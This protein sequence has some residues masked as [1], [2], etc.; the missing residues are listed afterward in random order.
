MNPAYFFLSLV[1]LLCTSSHALFPTQWHHSNNCN[2][3]LLCHDIFSLCW[4]YPFSIQ[5]WSSFF[6]VDKYLSWPIFPSSEHPVPLLPFTANMPQNNYLVNQSSIYPLPF[7][8]AHSSQVCGAHKSTELLLSRPL[9]AFRLINPMANSQS[10]FYV[11]HH[12]SLPY[13]WNTFF[14]WLL[15]LVTPDFPSKLLV[16]LLSLSTNVSLDLFFPVCWITFI[17]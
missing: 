9:V 17:L 10:V 11:W 5:P 14:I 6:S 12:S 13:H 7:S 2:F 16:A 1:F 4:I 15:K 3:L 8:L